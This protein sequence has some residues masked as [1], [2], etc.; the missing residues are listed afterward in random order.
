ML[1]LTPEHWKDY[2]LLDCGDF[3][4]LERFGKF[5]LRR[6]E[7]QAVWSKVWSEKEWQQQTDITFIAKSSQTYWFNC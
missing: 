6:P 4:K 3:E 5:V 2:E 7:P 1:L